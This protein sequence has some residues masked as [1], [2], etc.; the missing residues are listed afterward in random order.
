M[1]TSC[2]ANDAP[3]QSLGSTVLMATALFP[4]TLVNVR[5]RLKCIRRRAGQVPLETRS[6]IKLNLTVD[7]ALCHRLDEPAPHGHQ[8]TMPFMVDGAMNWSMS[9]AYIEQSLAPTLKRGDIVII[10]PCISNH[11]H[12]K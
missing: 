1:L 9:L 11:N 2:A 4:S 12:C 5:P 7:S 8:I 6:V 3:R 10:S